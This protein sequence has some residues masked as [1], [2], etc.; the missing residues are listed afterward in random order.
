MWTNYILY[1]VIIT[2]LLEASAAFRM[3]VQHRDVTPPHS[4]PFNFNNSID[5]FNFSLVN[6][7]GDRLAI[8]VGTTYIDDQPFEVQLD[9]GSADLWV[10]STGITFNTAE[11]THTPVSIGYGDGTSASGDI[12]VA[13][14]KFG[15]FTIEKQAFINAPGTN[16]TNSGDKGLL[17]IVP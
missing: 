5:P 6:T 3:P 15:D 1:G 13:T 14:V 2:L 8:Y 17:G 11:N 9:T 7:Q 16:A 12:Y 4:T 10:D